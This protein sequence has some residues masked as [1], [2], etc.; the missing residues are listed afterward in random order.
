ML[1]NNLQGRVFNEYNWGGYLI[2]R[3]QDLPV[4]VD[5]R[6]DLFG[7]KILG[8]WLTAV[9]AGEGWRD[10]LNKWQVAYVLIDPGRPLAKALPEDGWKLLYSDAQAVVYGK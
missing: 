5:G 6:T 7:D 2:W 3:T 8:E 9:Q 4:F 1:E 10:I